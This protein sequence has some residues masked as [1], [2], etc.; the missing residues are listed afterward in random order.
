MRFS[1]Y[2]VCPS[3]LSMINFKILGIRSQKHFYTRIMLQLT[4]NFGLLVTS[5][6]IT[7]LWKN[8]A[9]QQLHLRSWIVILLESVW[10]AEFQLVYGSNAGQ[11]KKLRSTFPFSQQISVGT[12]KMLL[13]CP[14]IGIMLMPYN[15]W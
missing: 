11:E 2:N 15:Q 3:G 8:W 7:K 6:W 5:F 4:F 9:F 12:T 1:V 14:V 13:T 10:E